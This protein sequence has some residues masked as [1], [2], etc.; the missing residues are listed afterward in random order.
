[1]M[2]VNLAEQDCEVNFPVIDMPK[3]MQVAWELMS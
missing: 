1:M 2:Y 3:R